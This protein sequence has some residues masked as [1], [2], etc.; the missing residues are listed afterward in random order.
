MNKSLLDVGAGYFKQMLT[1]KSK[2]A[3]KELVKVSKTFPSSKLCSNCGYKNDRLTLS[4]R[5]WTCISC[6]SVHDRDI[7]AAINIKQ[8]GRNFLIRLKSKIQAT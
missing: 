6:G 2:F 3:G 1:Y 7:N 8:E 4:D 5:L